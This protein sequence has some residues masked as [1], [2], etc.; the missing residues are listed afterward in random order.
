MSDKYLNMKEAAKIVG[1]SAP[2]LSTILKPSYREISKVG[3]ASRSMFALDKVLAFKKQREREKKEKSEATIKK[4]LRFVTR[5]PDHLIMTEA[6][7][8]TKARA[9]TILAQVRCKT[10]KGSDGKVVNFY[11][12][13]DLARMGSNSVKKKKQTKKTINKDD[14]FGVMLKPKKQERKCPKCGADLWEGQYVCSDCKKKAGVD[15]LDEEEA[16]GAIA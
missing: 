1:V 8:L 4:S 6:V 12:I 16:Y 15:D 2:F 5:P 7:Q 10:V 13:N 3:G 9:S 14:P 11:H